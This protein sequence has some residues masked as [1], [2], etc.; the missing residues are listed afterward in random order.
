MFCPGFC[1]QDGVQDTRAVIWNKMHTPYS[2]S[3]S[4]THCISYGVPQCPGHQILDRTSFPTSKNMPC[5]NQWHDHIGLCQHKQSFSKR[6]QIKTGA[7]FLSRV[8]RPRHWG[9]QGIK[10]WDFETLSNSHPFYSIWHP[11]VS[12]IEHLFKKKKENCIQLKTQLPKRAPN[13]KT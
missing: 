3:A 7:N 11:F 12:W 13:T 8:W 9:C 2:K 5:F 6:K 1:V 4:P 10:W